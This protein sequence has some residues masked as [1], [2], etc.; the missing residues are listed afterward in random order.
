MN[1][2]AFDAIMQDESQFGKVYACR[3]FPTNF[4]WRVLENCDM[5]DFGRE[6]LSRKGCVITEYGVISGRDQRLYTTLTAAPEIAEEQ[7]EDESETED[8]SEKITL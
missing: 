4:D 2:Y 6:L 1:E 8:A 3:V 5:Y 7:T